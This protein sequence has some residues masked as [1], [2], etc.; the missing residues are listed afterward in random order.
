VITDKRSVITDGMFGCYWRKVLL[1]RLI[2]T[3]AM[4][5]YLL[6]KRLV[7]T[8]ETFDYYR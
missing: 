5:D 7:L 2:I 8:N 1:L 4:F 6:I 3:D